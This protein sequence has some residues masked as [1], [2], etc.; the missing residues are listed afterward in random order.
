MRPFRDKRALVKDFGLVAQWLDA[1]QILFGLV[2]DPVEMKYE[3]W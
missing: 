1:L 2:S 3:I